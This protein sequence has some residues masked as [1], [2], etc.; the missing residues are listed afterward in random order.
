MLILYIDTD[1]EMQTKIRESSL[2]SYAIECFENLYD[3]YKW[4]KRNQIPDYIITDF[5][6]DQP[7]QLQSIK[8]LL[9]KIRLRNTKMIGYSENVNAE[10]VRLAMMH[11]AVRLFAKSELIPALKDYL[12]MVKSSKLTATEFVPENSTRSLGALTKRI[13]MKK[14]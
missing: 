6:M 11:K 5:E 10:Y 1:T 3:A 12:N 4:I 13:A 9:T 2:D 8:F 14:K 7:T